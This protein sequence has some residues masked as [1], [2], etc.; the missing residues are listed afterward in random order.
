MRP[1]A[2]P[3]GACRGHSLLELLA[4]LVVVSLAAGIVLPR[5]PGMG[6]VELDAAAGA[7]AARLSAARERAIVEGRPVRVD[8]REGLPS[9]IRVDAVDAG[10]T[11]LAARALTL[12]PD[13]DALEATATLADEQGRRAH[14]VV[15]AGFA[16]ARVTE[17][18]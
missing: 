15:P 3:R 16:P 14:V 17:R 1:G 5:L 11:E 13:G 4:V 18:P 2:E 12:E 7:L 9:A 10:G 8:L 6:A